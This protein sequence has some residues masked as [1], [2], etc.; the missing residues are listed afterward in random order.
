[1]RT[2]K[3]AL[4]P[5]GQ[6]PRTAFTPPFRRMKVYALGW[7]G[8]LALASLLAFGIHYWP[9]SLPIPVPKYSQE[10]AFTEQEVRVSVP[11]R[12]LIGE[13]SRIDDRLY[14]LSFS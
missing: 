6:I 3:L 5:A 10:I 13:L 1:M 4:R 7:L 2:T 9:R 8:A 12:E 11:D 14:A